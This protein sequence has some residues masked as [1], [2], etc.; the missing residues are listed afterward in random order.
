M[1]KPPD[2]VAIWYQALTLAGGPLTAEI[3]NRAWS[4]I[5][6]TN[7]RNQDPSVIYTFLEPNLG[8]SLEVEQ[9]QLAIK[10]YGGS[11]QF[12]DANRVM[13]A[14]QEQLHDQYLDLD[15]GGLANVWETSNATGQRDP[16]TGWPFAITIMSYRAIAKGE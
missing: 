7:W 8:V 13:R 9:G 14:A 11:N 2:S 3:G 5:A 1:G 10:C 6:P 12:A 16:D 15:A 4:P